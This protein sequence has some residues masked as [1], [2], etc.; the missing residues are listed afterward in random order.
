MTDFICRLFH[1]KE[2]HCLCFYLKNV[3]RCKSIECILSCT[4]SGKVT[5]GLECQQRPEG[6][7]DFS[8]EPIEGNRQRAQH[9]E[10]PG[11]WGNLEQ[12]GDQSVQYGCQEERQ[13]AR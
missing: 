11:Q 6:A 7:W 1:H 12:L 5:L 4:G 13:E 2:I 3:H 8:R 9:K 10:R